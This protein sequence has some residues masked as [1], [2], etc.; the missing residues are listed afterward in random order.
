[1]DRGIGLEY[2]GAS[3]G[4]KQEDA[5]SGPL[6]LNLGLVSAGEAGDSITLDIRFPVTKDGEAIRAQITEKVRQA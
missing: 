1:M 2:D 3:L 4:V 6:T 5:E